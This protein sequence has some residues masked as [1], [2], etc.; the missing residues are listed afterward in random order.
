MTFPLERYCC[1]FAVSVLASQMTIVGE[2]ILKLNFLT[3]RL[4]VSKSFIWFRIIFE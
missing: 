3:C 1:L 4:Y 2:I